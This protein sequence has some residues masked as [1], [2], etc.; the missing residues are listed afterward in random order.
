MKGV[1]EPFPVE[2]DKRNTI[3][4]PI[5]LAS[6]RPHRLTSYYYVGNGI[7]T[8][9]E[10]VLVGINTDEMDSNQ[11]ITITLSRAAV[12]ELTDKLRGMVTAVK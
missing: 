2:N 9:D 7:G 11:Q 1:N 8:E 12:L 6:G 10:Y 5:S 3:A 4:V